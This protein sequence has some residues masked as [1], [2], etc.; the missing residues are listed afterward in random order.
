[1]LVICVL[2][3]QKDTKTVKMM[4]QKKKF[5]FGYIKDLKCRVLELPYQG[6]DLSMVIL[7][8]D[9]IQDES[10]GL[11]KVRP[12]SPR[13]M[14]GPCVCVCVCVCVSGV[15]ACSL[16]SEVTRCSFPVSCHSFVK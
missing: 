7:L 9:D 1:M 8:P 3:V 13:V 16:F 5:P 10:T 14:R 2:I 4:Y 12:P 6:E 11:K 15:G